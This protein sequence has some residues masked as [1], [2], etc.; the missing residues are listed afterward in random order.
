M[1]CVNIEE[2]CFFFFGKFLDV[3]LY[4]KLIMN[5]N[6]KDGKEIFN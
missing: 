1:C 3:F 6:R 4:D 5:M 2:R